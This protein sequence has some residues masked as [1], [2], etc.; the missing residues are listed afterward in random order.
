VAS[1]SDGRRP[2]VRADAGAWRRLGELLQRRRAE[3]GYR[4]RPAFTAE[5]D[6]NIRLVTDI[7]NAHRPNTFSIGALQHIARAYAVTYESVTAVLH[8]GA[9]GLD[10]AAAASPPAPLAPGPPGL[11]PSMADAAR[12]A[13]ARP[14]SDRIQ[15]R[16]RDLAARGVTSPSGADVFPGRPD[17]ARAWDALSGRWPLNDVIW[18]TADL[19]ARDARPPG[20]GRREGAAG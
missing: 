3:L 2:A 14:W 10:P 20:E 6:I 8:G 18:M 7:E 15:E 19:L 12:V 9:D 5:R 16:L 13:A 4:Y 1:S 17:D 11:P